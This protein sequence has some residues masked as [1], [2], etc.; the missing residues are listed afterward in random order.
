[1]DS[2]TN[3]L[4]WLAVT[5]V[6][7]IGAAVV[8]GPANAEGAAQLTYRVNH[9]VFGDIG[10]YTNTVEPTSDGATVKTKAHFEVKML[11]VRMYREEADRTERWQGNRLVSFRGVT[12]KADGREAVQ[13]D[14][15]GNTFG[16]GWRKATIPAPG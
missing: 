11:G 7:L 10:T 2:R 4:P 5:M 15:H 16:I 13:G 6:G 1:M 12:N 3:A 8:V 9:S 14:A